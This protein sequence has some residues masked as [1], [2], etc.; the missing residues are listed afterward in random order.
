M[1]YYTTLRLKV[2]DLSDEDVT[3]LEGVY[4]SLVD[5]LEMYITDDGDEFVF[6]DVKFEKLKESLIKMSSELSWYKFVLKGDGDDP[7]DLWRGFL[8]RGEF[9]KQKAKIVFEEAPKDF[10]FLNRGN[11]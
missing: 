3:D 7:R 10:D 5:S 9:A 8:F 2:Y 1:G 6:H 4:D 11:L